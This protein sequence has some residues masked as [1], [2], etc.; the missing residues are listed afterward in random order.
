[1]AHLKNRLSWL[2]HDG[3]FAVL[4]PPALPEVWVLSRAEAS[5]NSLVQS[6]A[7][8]QSHFYSI[9][10]APCIIAM[11]YHQWACRQ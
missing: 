1:M 3:V 2:G 7:R 5:R 4:S 6:C 10:K 8:L 9:N 11:T